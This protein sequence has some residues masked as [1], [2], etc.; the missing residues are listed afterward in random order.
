MI[1]E[2]MRI[3]SEKHLS[4]KLMFGSCGQ[5]CGIAY[6]TERMPASVEAL[7]Q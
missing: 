4:T 3:P 6:H 5:S 1:Q 2:G 7:C